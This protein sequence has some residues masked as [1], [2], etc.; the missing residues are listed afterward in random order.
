MHLVKMIKKIYNIQVLDMIF[1]FIIIINIFQILDIDDP[2]SFWGRMT[3][4]TPMC[5]TDIIASLNH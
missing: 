4:D 1:T 5:S 2:I 3:I